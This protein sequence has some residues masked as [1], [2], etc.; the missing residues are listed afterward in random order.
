MAKTR[1]KIFFDFQVSTIDSSDNEA[2]YFRG[3]IEIFFIIFEKHSILN[4]AMLQMNCAPGQ[5][6]VE[7]QWPRG[8]HEN[9]TNRNVWIKF[10]M[11][12]NFI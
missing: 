5:I 11:N 3:R 8:G 10:H 2:F 7:A 1:Y 12:K 6:T 9:G 4:S